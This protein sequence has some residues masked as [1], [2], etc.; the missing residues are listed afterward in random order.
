MITHK[1]KQVIKKLAI[2]DF[3]TY[4]R[5]EINSAHIIDNLNLFAKIAGKQQVIPVLKANAYGHGIKEVARILNS[6]SVPFLAVDGYFE[7]AE[8]AG[9]TKH[10]ILVMGVIKKSN[11]HLLDTKK[12][13]FAVQDTETLQALSKLNRPVNVHMELNTGMNRLGLNKN[14]IDD[15]LDCLQKHPKL[16]LE[17]IMSHLA[18]ADNPDT[19]FTLAQQQKF[20]DLVAYIKSKGCKPEFI[21]LSQTAGSTKTASKHTNTIRLGIGLYGINPLPTNDPQH[22]ILNAL[23]PVMELKSTIIKTQHINKHDRVSYN[24]TFEANASSKIG[25]LPLGYYEGYPRELSNV[26]IVQ[27]NNNFLP[28]AGR[29]CM[30]HTMINLED[31]DADIGSEITLI[32]SNPAN[33]NSVANICKN[34]DIFSYELLCGITSKIKRSIL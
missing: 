12:C 5:L 14:E 27:Y 21:H 10:K 11:T 33:P 9:S 31:T 7:A 4:N 32:S 24:G 15:Y 26:G 22:S 8:I 25:I 23:K 6:T 29:V 20:D 13:S 30:N 1:I 17:G 2:A 34:N 16:N 19:S 28:V 18:D 3:D